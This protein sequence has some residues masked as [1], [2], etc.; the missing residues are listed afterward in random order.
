MA[1]FCRRHVTAGGAG[2][3]GN[4]AW[5]ASMWVCVFPDMA[6]P[7]FVKPGN[8]HE[9]AGSHMLRQIA[10]FSNLCGKPFNVFRLSR[11]RS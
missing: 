6:L 7:R 9:H 11:S 4:A 10:M 3:K 2:S 5:R 1:T 8:R